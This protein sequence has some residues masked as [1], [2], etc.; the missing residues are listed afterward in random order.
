MGFLNPLLYQIGPSVTNAFNDVVDGA[1]MG[2]VNAGF[3]AQAGW[4][5]ATGWGSPNYKILSSAVL[6]LP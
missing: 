1:N 6:D 2:C 3:Y 5:P 4:D